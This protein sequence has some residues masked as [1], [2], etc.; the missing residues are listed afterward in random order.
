MDVAGA[1]LHNLT[2]EE[3]WKLPTT[4]WIDETEG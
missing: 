3:Q 1:A 4:V 2:M